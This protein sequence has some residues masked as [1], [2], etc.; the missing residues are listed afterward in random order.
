M[1]LTGV[2]GCRRVV[3]V[4]VS[5]STCRIGLVLDP[6]APWRA[7]S[8]MGQWIATNSPERAASSMAGGTR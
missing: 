6:E 8:E 5:A 7:R 2:G 1:L 3:G 4:S